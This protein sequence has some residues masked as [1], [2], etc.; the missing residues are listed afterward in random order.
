MAK[1]KK[2]INKSAEIREYLARNPTAGPKRVQSALAEKGIEVSSGLV[3]R[4][5]YSASKKKAPANQ[6]RTKK[7]HTKSPGKPLMG[8][9]AATKKKSNLSKAADTRTRD[10]LRQAGDLMRQAM[11]LVIKVGAKEAKQLVNRAEGMVRTIRSR[12]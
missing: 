1:K 3:G 2:A 6:K 10:E 5:K 8:R 9:A 12:K 11:D 7:A 4:V